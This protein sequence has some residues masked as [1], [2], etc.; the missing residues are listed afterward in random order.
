MLR[1]QILFSLFEVEST[2]RVGYW[3]LDTKCYNLLYRLNCT[4]SKIDFFIL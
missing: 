1:R 3:R 4:G 2:A